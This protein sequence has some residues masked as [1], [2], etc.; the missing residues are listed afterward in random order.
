MPDFDPVIFYLGKLC[1]NGHDW[2]STGTSLRYRSTQGCTECR[3]L[4]ALNPEAKANRKRYGEANREKIKQANHDR[5]WS[6]PERYKLQ[7]KQYREKKREHCKQLRLARYRKNPQKFIN[8]VKLYYL[9]NREAVLSRRKL[10]YATNPQHRTV[11]LQ[12]NRRRKAVKKGNHRFNVT[13][14]QLDQRLNVF[15]G[16]CAY[17]RTLPEKI[18]VDHFIAVMKGG[19]DCLGN[20]LPACESCNVD[21]SNKDP[22]QW[23]K[24]KSFYSKQRWLEILRILGKTDDNYDQIPLF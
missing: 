17:C 6:N 7:M 14:E 23:F 8:A 15:G 22:K 2:N 10:A 19:S 3:K 12:V 4:Y 11:K 18:T 21:K 20:Y 24:S 1:K 9:Q 13:P 16:C 5:Y